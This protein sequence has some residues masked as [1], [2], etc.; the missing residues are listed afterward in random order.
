MRS[1]RRLR[2]APAAAA[3]GLRA[4]RG[5]IGFAATEETVHQ[6]P[7]GAV[8]TADALG[9]GDDRDDEQRGRRDGHAAHRVEVDDR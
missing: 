5:P 2:V 6:P 8:H 9:L 4:R 7:H 3:A 1:A